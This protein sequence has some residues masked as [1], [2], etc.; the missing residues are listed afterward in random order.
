MRDRGRETQRDTQTYRDR[1]RVKACID[2]ECQR[3]IQTDCGETKSG[4]A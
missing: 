3:E 2:K 4:N 1:E